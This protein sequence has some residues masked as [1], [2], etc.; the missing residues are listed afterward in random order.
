MKANVM[1]SVKDHFRPEFI[2]R[3]DATI[4]FRPLT[5]ETMTPITR[6][7]VRRLAERMDDR[8]VS[9]EVSEAAIEYLA[10]AG[11]DPAYGARPLKRVIQNEVQDPLAELIINSKITENQHVKIDCND[12]KLSFDI[13]DLE[14]KET[15]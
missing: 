11:Y 15:L 1:E 7:Q 3:L 4:V 8:K 9:L 13:I 12:Q 14:I 5:R 6:I 10:D 2:N